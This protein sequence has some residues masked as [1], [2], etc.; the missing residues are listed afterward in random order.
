V[1]GD[2][3]ANLARRVAA[4][5]G[6]TGHPLD[7]R[8]RDSFAAFLAAAGPVDVLVNNAGVAP[9]GR[10]LDLDPALLDLVVDVNLRGV[11]NGMRLA[12]PA[13]IERGSG[14]VVNIASLAGR[15]PLPGAAVYGASKHAVVGLTSAVRTELRGS[16]VTVSAVLPTF[17]RTELVSGLSLNALPKVD[18]SA[19]AAAVVRVASSA[20][21][22]GLV[23]VPRWMTAVGAFHA[24]LPPWLRDAL[25]ARALDAEQAIDPGARA[26]Y[27]RRV[28]DLLNP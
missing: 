24:V 27:E 21:P 16:G 2:V 28:S 6:G 17:A 3:D 14:L 25:A 4:E 19:V 22:P 9:A 23:T 5:L 12:L 15:V 7:V 11:L 18:A 13:M 20:R 1:I 26:G 10:F 8:D